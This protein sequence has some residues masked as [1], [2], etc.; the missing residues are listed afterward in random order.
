MLDI[1]GIH[2]VLEFVCVHICTLNIS[3]VELISSGQIK[4]LDLID[5]GLFSLSFIDPLKTVI[6]ALSQM[7]RFM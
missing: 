7:Y 4:E 5:E 2:A 6:F 1:A 3:Y